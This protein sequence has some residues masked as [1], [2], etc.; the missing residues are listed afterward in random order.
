[1]TSEII[2]FLTK[3]LVFRCIFGQVYF[4]DEL[5][6]SF[7]LLKLLQKMLYYKVNTLRKI[8]LYFLNQKTPKKF[9]IVNFL[10]EFCDQFNFP[11]RNLRWIYFCGLNS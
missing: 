1:M 10:C 11:L 6:M 9:T 5:K 7:A 8:A 3:L 2:Y 4:S